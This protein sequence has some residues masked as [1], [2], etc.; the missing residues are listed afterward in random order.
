VGLSIVVGPRFDGTYGNRRACLSIISL[1]PAGLPNEY[2]GCSG[3]HS[4]P[5][6]IL[7]LFAVELHQMVSVFAYQVAS[8][9]V[10]QFRDVRGQSGDLVASPSG[11]VGKGF[12]GRRARV[13]YNGSL[14]A[15]PEPGVMRLEKCVFDSARV[16][17]LPGS[18]STT[19]IPNGRSSWPDRC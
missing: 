14:V 4:L 19:R 8:L 16:R 11:K 15:S 6:Q 7:E 10:V 17:K 12:G 13:A 1:R 9:R 3:L 18:I 5:H 2:N